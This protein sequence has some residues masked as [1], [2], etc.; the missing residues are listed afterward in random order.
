MS[1]LSFFLVTV[2]LFL[3][4]SRCFFFVL[5]IESYRTT[6]STQNRKKVSVDRFY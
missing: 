6:E 2:V 5:A 3:V 4:F 1:F